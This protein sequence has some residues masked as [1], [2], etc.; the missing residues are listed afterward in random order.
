MK[1]LT[2]IA[3]LVVCVSFGGAIAADFDS[4]KVLVCAPV[5]AMNC[6][7]GEA[8]SKVRPVDIGAP[9]FFRVD[10]A[11]NAIIGPK[12][13]TQVQLM[14]QGQ[15]QLLLQGTELGYGW[16]LAL[17]SDNGTMALTIA[18]HESAAVLFGSCT[19]Q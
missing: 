19:P 14:E 10:L 17:N 7:S 15:D 6:V 3:W 2:R 8:C 16:T 18:D 4:S 12:R 13:T 1:P 9:A 11:N 5:E